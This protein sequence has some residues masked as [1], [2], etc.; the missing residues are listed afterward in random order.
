MR[1]KSRIDALGA[2]HH[3]IVRGIA[4]KKVFDE[5]ADYDFFVE[6]L[7]LILIETRTQ[8]FAWSLLDNHCHLL[9]KTRWRGWMIREM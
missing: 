7:G 2:L 4:R 9:F 6:R 8:C 1:R 5:N 3:I